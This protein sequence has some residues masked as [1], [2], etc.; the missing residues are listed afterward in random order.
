MKSIELFAGAGGLGMGLHRAGFEPVKVV[1]WDRYACDTIRE[2]QGID[3]SPVKH[4]PLTE[5]D[6]RAVDF[7]PLEDTIDL[8]SGGPPCQP[9]SLGG[10]HQA[11]ND[12]R[13]MFPQAI[14]A[15]RETRP[16]AFVFENVK[17]LTRAA[18]RNYFE[19]I[20]LQLEHP[21]VVARPDEDWT[22]HLGRLE[23]HHLLGSRDGLHYRV[24]A[25]VLNAADY[26]VP[27]KRERV[28]FVGFRDDLDVEWHFPRATHGLDRLIWDQ[29]RDGSYW[30]RHKVAIKD[31]PSEAVYSQ[32]ADRMSER[33]VDCAWNT[34]R[35]AIAGLPDP[36]FEKD[37]S[38][39]I[40]NHRF[41][42]GARSYP[43]HTGSPLDE[44]AKTLKAGVHGVPGGENMLARHDGS[45]RYFTVRESARLQ[46][47]PDNYIFH[48]SWTETMRQLGNAVPVRLAEVIGRGVA[49][50]LR[51]A[52]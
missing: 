9:F 40:P 45:V 39:K 24:V 25:R 52:A 3:Y 17:G 48:G 4:W 33:P 41:Q 2:N 12:T 6:V 21:G 14:R 35:D 22:D 31:R 8:V 49:L 1:E 11:Y 26:G 29:H 44:P 34:V 36:E 20:K 47:F 27:Q 7:S 5:G 23:N 46:T 42:G 18:F 51:F 10:R 30:E 13:D 43:G 15:V 32:R 16:R 28:V 50:K 19:Y 37:K 38:R